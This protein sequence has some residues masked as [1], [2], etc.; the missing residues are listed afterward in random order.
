[1]TTGSEYMLF[2]V[3]R[4][5]S[6]AWIMENPVIP[7]GEMAYDTTQNRLKI[8]DGVRHWSA[9]PW[10]YAELDLDSLTIPASKISDA[11][12]V[13]RALLVAVDQAAARAAIGAGTGD[14][15]SNLVVGTSAETACEGND[16]RLSDERVPLEDSVDTHRIQVGA[17]T[18][19]RLSVEVMEAIS[20]AA[21][22][23]VIGPGLELVSSASP[24][25][26]GTVSTIITVV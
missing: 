24:P 8:G 1:M 20:N 16:P 3:R 26:P 2:R 21:N 18:A 10:L 13:G 7:N 14:G 6:S 11:T 22:N 19:S 5:E 17:V 12:T 25:A 4:D 23:A 15:T 9:L